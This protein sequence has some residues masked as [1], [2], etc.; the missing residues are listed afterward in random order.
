MT[1]PSRETLEGCV[2]AKLAKK[3][4]ALM[5]HAVAGYPSLEANRR[6]LLAMEEAGVD[7]VELQLPFSEPIAD[8][9]LFL[10][11]NQAAIE[12]G[13]TWSAYFEL[14]RWAS[15]SCS[16][17][18]LFMGYANSVFRMGEEAFCDR[19]VE[20]GLRGFILADLPCEEAANLHRRARERGLDPIL[21]VTP[22][23]TPERIAKIAAEASGFL[24]CVARKGVTGKRTDLSRGVAEFIARVRGSTKLPLGLGFGLKTPEDV[25]SIRGLADIAI[26][27]TAC[28][29]AWE[30]EGEAGYRRFLSGLVAATL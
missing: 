8:G 15:R 17:P 14:A 22:T 18:V 5:A 9:P 29:E 21:I 7:L 12:D 23:S 24:Y 16:F 28:L 30:E 3:P 20:A 27:G 13:L 25:A 1:G 2:R 4:L 26:V 10:K 11:A 6:M 19:L